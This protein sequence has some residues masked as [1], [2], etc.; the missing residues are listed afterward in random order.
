MTKSRWTYGG[1][2]SFV[3]YTRLDGERKD[4]HSFDP[5]WITEN[6]YILLS[7][8]TE[9][10]YEG[11]PASLLFQTWTGELVDSTE[12]KTIEMI[13]LEYDDTHAVYD[14]KSMLETWGNDDFSTVYSISVSDKGENNL[15]VS[16]MTIT[17][18]DIPTE[19]IADLKGCT[20][21][22]NGA[23]VDLAM[24][25]VSANESAQSEEIS[26]SYDETDNWESQTDINTDG[27]SEV[28]A[29]ET[30]AKQA[31]ENQISSMLIYLVIAIVVAV[32]AITII[33]ISLIKKRKNSWH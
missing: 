3:T 31:E 27:N 28:T 19:S 4:K 12:D 25:N 1:G 21:L 9:G 11:C 24:Y 33:V 2:Y 17:N 20:L 13:P 5:N 29:V 14:Y 7:Y 30:E 32:I 16:S 22:Q 10:E 15:F 18:V 8:E 23:E 26:T 6:S